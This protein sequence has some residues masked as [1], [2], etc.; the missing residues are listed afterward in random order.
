MINKI[1]SFI[2]QAGKIALKNQGQ[3]DFQKSNFKSEGINDPVTETDL[4]VSQ[5]FSDFVSQNFSDLDYLII[6]EESVSNLGDSP[7]EKLGAAEYVF[8]IDPIDGTLTYANKYPFWG[9]SVGV[10]K[11]GKPFVGACYAPALDL[12]VWSDET[13]AYLRE[14]GKITELAPLPDAAPIVLEYHDSKKVHVNENNND[15][16][17]QGLR[18]YSQVLSAIYVA[19]GRARGYYYQAFIWDIAG[20]MP[21]LDKVGIK[22]Q[23]YDDGL[24]FDLKTCLG[25]NLRAQ[26][27]YIVSK[28]EYFDYLKSI[29]DIK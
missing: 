22:I 11:N 4:A 16:Q 5:M 6:D 12:L 29:V 8:V 19:I 18:V 14:F 7:V 3:I 13:K 9:I 27:V 2:E 15:K 17:V 1:L 20:I 28:P 26:K 21:V 23:G 24:E 10:F 25:K